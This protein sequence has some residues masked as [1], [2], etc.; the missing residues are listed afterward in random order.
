[1]NIQAL[2]DHYN[3]VKDTL[4]N[5]LVGQRAKDYAANFNHNLQANFP[6]I[7][8]NPTIDDLIDTGFNI[9]GVG[10]IR[11]PKDMFLNLT[12]KRGINNGRQNELDALY[13]LYD[14]YF[15]NN[16]A[17]P[18]DMF[19]RAAEENRNHDF[20][21]HFANGVHLG[22]KPSNATASD[23]LK[24]LSGGQIKNVKDLGINLSTSYT[25]FDLLHNAINNPNTKAF[26][27]YEAKVGEL[28]D[29]LRSFNGGQLTTD[30]RLGRLAEN[31]SDINAATRIVN[32][33][34]FD[35]FTNKK[36]VNALLRNLR[37][38]E[39]AYNANGLIDNNYGMFSNA[40]NEATSFYNRQK[41]DISKLISS[42]YYKQNKPSVIVKPPYPFIHTASHI[43][44]IAPV[45]NR[46]S[47]IDA[48]EYTHRAD[49]AREAAANKEA[50][51][52]AARD[53]TKTNLIN[54]FNDGYTWHKI[55]DP[56]GL[57]AEGTYLKHCV[58]GYC[59]KV[60]DGSSEIYSLRKP[61]GTPL[62]TIEWDP[63]DNSI[64]QIRGKSN[65]AVKPEHS[66]YIDPF[67]TS[68]D[69]YRRSPDYF[70]NQG[71]NSFEDLI[72]NIDFNQ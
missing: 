28:A 57:K 52:I 11:S 5:G 51:E 39:A 26:K 71:I 59:D 68:A 30:T 4:A 66:K 13:K 18:N 46:M 3:E 60:K 50:M 14:N 70:K 33:G 44:D 48:I 38:R 54:S 1:M 8:D 24:H 56:D 23:A 31:L 49:V 36:E 21:R 34:K 15:K 19:V 10:A 62:Y 45:T 41:D 35:K 42:D 43:A 12:Q 20:L 64:V 32:N 47:L 61:D 29:V 16:W 2:I 9:G 40:L 69:I 63:K 22:L 6:A 65:S 7:K 37:E 72:K 27:S 25:G 58:G 53:V 67:K 17:T 55:S